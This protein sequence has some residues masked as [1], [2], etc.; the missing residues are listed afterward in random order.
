MRLLAALLQ[1]KGAD[2]TNELITV[3][4]YA[5]STRCNLRNRRKLIPVNDRTKSREHEFMAN[6]QPGVSGAGAT[7]ALRGCILSIVIWMSTVDMEF[8]S[9]LKTVISVTEL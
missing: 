5:L 4:L 6:K 9:P 3:S 1:R 7:L 2:K 8:V